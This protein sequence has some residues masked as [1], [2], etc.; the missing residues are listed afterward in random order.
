LECAWASRI[1]DKDLG[2]S[3]ARAGDVHVATG[4]SDLFK[5]R[6]EGNCAFDF[7]L[8]PR[9]GSNS[10]G[11]PAKNHTDEVNCVPQ[12]AVQEQ[13]IGADNITLGRD[14]AALAIGGVEGEMLTTD[15]F[16]LGVASPICSGFNVLAFYTPLQEAGQFDD[17]LVGLGL[18]SAAVGWGPL[19]LREPGTIADAPDA[20]P[21]YRT[22]HG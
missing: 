17:A 6:H 15:L 1:I 8:C 13:A 9:E 18:Y 20:V 19:R 3:E 16:W 21:P 5:S 10:G 2:R 14:S 4:P 7:R 12:A 22:F 11:R